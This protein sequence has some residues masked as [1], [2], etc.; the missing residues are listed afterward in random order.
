M[1]NRNCRAELQPKAAS[2]AAVEAAARAWVGTPYRHQGREHRVACDC[3][4]KN[5]EKRGQGKNGVRVRFPLIAG[6]GFRIEAIDRLYLP[7][8]PRFAGFNLWGTATPG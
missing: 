3:L 6:T 4:R 8:T 5:E 2:R 7:G 1:Q